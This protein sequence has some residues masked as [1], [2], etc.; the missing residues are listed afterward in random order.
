MDKKE[1]LRKFRQTALIACLFIGMLLLMQ[2]NIPSTVSIVFFSVALVLVIWNSI[3]TF[4]YSKAAKLLQKRS[5][6][7]YEKAI[8]Y[9]EKAVKWGVNENGQLS[10]G[11]LM[12]QYGDMEKGKEIL[13]ALTKGSKMKEEAK[14][15][16]S[17]YY[18]VKKDLDK[19]IELCLEAREKGK[20]DKNLYVNL[21]TYYM[22]KGDLKEYRKYTKECNDLSLATPATLDLEAS[23]Y[24]MA[25][26]WK[27]AGEHLKS[28]FDKTV[29]GYK[30][31]Y[32]HNAMVLLHYGDWEGAVK[33]L[34]A[35]STNTVDSNI[36]VYT[37]KEIE[38][39]IDLIIDENTRWGMLEIVDKA[40][41]TFIKG[42]MPQ[43][44]KGLEKPETPALPSFVEE[45]VGPMA[46]EIQDEDSQ[47]IDTSLN[48]DDEEWLKRHQ[49]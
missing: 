3:G 29:P 7:N 13:E 24:M 36:S 18:W 14:I 43:P 1:K 12:I 34:R 35:I 19:A 11:T 2:K 10:A 46:T 21:C 16:L 20:K 40:P 25:G 17:M 6:E 39:I 8:P 32:I 44:R 22:E 27:K 9:L 47:D 49:D 41:E 4:Y 31:P 42:Q 26:D 23:F 28:I 15:S 45:S 30:D 5:K 38:E 48:D 33:N 37:Q